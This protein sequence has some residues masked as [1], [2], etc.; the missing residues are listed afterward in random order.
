MMVRGLLT[1]TSRYNNRQICIFFEDV[2]SLVNLVENDRCIYAY[3]NL[4]LYGLF[5][6]T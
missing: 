4:Q 6:F 3:K 2:V 5:S 1:Y